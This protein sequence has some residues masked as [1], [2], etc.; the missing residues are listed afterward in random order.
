MCGLFVAAEFA[1]VTVDRSTLERA[2]ESGDRAAQGGLAALK[3]L[4]TQ[5][6]GAQIGITITNLAIGFLAEPAIAEL[7]DAPLADLGL[8]SDL[9]QGVSIAIALFLSTI[10]TMVFGELVPKNLAIARPLEVVRAVQGFQRGFTTIVHGPIRLFNGWANWIL[11][12]MGL[13]PQE[14]LASARSPQELASL[15]NRS[16]EQGTLEQG[17]ARLVTRTIAFG[18]RRADDAMTPRVGMHTIEPTESVN[19][20]Y[21]LAR[22]TGHSRFPVV[23]EGVD[24]V[25]G[26]VHVK[27][28]VEVDAE[29][30]ERVSV[31]DIMVEP[32]VV[33]S[34]LELD[35]LLELLREGRLQMAVVVDEFGA[36]DGVV[37]ME[38]L[39][40]ELVGDVVDE[41]DN[42][43]A[44]Y[45]R[46]PDGSW[47]LSGLLRPDEASEIIGVPLPEDEE[48]ETLAGLL[49]LH[50]EHIADEGDTA[51]IVVERFDQPDV[52]VT[53]RAVEMH[54]LRV[55][56]INVSLEDIPDEDDEADDREPRNGD[57][58]GR[59]A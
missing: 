16:A 56:K 14:E 9:S 30:R 51:E 57:E 33:P 45:R 1:L 49:T 17:T 41:H 42:T 48:Y 43:E 5:L 22:E 27:H 58:E 32:V 3:T 40:E 2:A 20:V 8:G 12:R 59:R 38:D 55:D 35:P 53:L 39:I 11:R 19:A 50:L 52:R 23:P 28:V 6:S 4:S 26:I 29:D 25:V 15:V 18:D 10:L 36:I 7:I 46:E 31:G 47:L 13:E 34:S 44:S 21:R 37:T 54:G 24:Q